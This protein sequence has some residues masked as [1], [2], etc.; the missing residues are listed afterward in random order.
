MSRIGYNYLRV[1]DVA[2]EMEHANKANLGGG[3]FFQNDIRFARD[4]KAAR[5]ERKVVLRNYPDKTLPQSVDDWLKINQPLA[6]GGLIVQTV[7]EIG[8]G[9]DVIDF[10][11]ALL[12]RIKRDRIKMNVGILGLS[13]GTPGPDEWYRAERLIRLAADLRDQVHLVLHEYYGAVVTSG[14]IGGNPEQFII[15]PMWPLDTSRITMWHVGRYRFLKQ[16]CVSKGLPLP[17][18][19]IGE[20]GADYVGDIGDWLKTLPSDGGKY[21]SVDGWRDLVSVWR[22]WW[23]FWDGAS[24]Y[25]RQLSYADKYIYTD[26]EI[27]LIALY[28]RWNDGSW[29]TYQTNPELD[30]QIEDYGQI[31]APIP[32]PPVEEPPIVVPTPQPPPHSDGEEESETSPDE[33]PPEE[34]PEETPSTPE[35]PTPQPAAEPAWMKDLPKGTRA[36]IALGRLMLQYGDELRGF[37]VDD[38]AYQIIGELAV[39]LDAKG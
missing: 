37:I 36:R 8:F 9:Q 2:A 7:N 21:D 18:I 35:E 11:V 12:E 34:M 13:V 22:K 4:F 24:S 29:G 39:M 19:I 25:M 16:Y 28:A 20:F 10:H 26:E 15:P 33:E 3:L 5:P 32:Q 14:F 31:A 27:E 23:P 6:E 1:P 17:R 38:E 30:K